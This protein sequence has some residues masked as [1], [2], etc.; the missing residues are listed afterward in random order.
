[1]H[2]SAQ[3]RARASMLPPQSS[4]STNSLGPALNSPHM[5]LQQH[6]KGL[7]NLCQPRKRR[8][9]SV[10]CLQKLHQLTHRLQAAYA[11][12][13]TQ[14]LPFVRHLSPANTPYHTM[15]SRYRRT[16]PC[17]QRQTDQGP[18]KGPRI[19]SRVFNKSSSSY[20][21]HTMSAT[22]TLQFKPA[23]NSLTVPWK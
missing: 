2:C 13:S 16:D 1:M 20:P 11:R 3:P 5:L 10:Y 14:T 9:Q 22:Q 19:L 8:L 23:N 7:D 12:Q 21:H 18:P 17:E 6:S 4:D 15:R